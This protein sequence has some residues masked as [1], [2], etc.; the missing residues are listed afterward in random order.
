VTL[1][2]KA[3][4]GHSGSAWERF[5]TEDSASVALLE[6]A[7]AMLPAEDS[8]LRARVLARLGE[9]I[10]YSGDSAERVPALA[11]EAVEMARRVD[12]LE[13]LADA[14]SSA[15][16]AH[17]R[18]GQQERRLEVAYELVSVAEQLGD[19]HFLAEARAWRAIVLIELCRRDAAD[20]DLDRHAR[21][22]Y[23]LQQPELL[24][25]SA[26]LRSMRAL[27]SG[28]WVE[29]ERAA[30]EVLQVGE[31]SRALDAR[32]YYAA[33]MLAL[34]NEQSRLG[35]LADQLEGLV[36]DVGALPAWRAALAWSLVQAGRLDDAR[37]EL[38]DLRRAG[39][40]ALPLDANFVPALAIL[41]HVAGELRDAD[42][43]ADV[44]PLLR[45][46]TDYWVVLGP[47]PATLGPVAYSVGLLNL[48]LAR[49]DKAGRYFVVA[50]EKSELMRARPY[51]ARAQ[52]GLAE[53]LRA[54]RGAGHAERAA[55][56]EEEAM[57]IAR[58]L[59]MTRL[60]G[61]AEAVAPS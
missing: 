22:A 45:P 23:S 7:L 25:H 36:R 15:Q 26:A 16:Y 4:L 55:Q 56:L 48:V 38:Y 18:P 8:P 21:L 40:A 31:R 6:E 30:N 49:P 61:E 47:G 53:A 54:G 42:L 10:Y 50:T 35:E 14:L 44:E 58:E 2:A 17:W 24:M 19:L 20:A 46:Y 37:A 32:Q 33:E 59:E 43:A 51:L 9:A 52:A 57:A 41:A 3:A 27:L 13:A 12:D 60:L 39:L 5:G 1:F 29:G 34:R 11:R 28:R